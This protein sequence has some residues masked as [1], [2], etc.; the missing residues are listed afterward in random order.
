MTITGRSMVGSSKYHSPG[1]DFFF[2]FPFKIITWSKM[3][4]FPSKF[5]ERSI[6]GFWHHYYSPWS[7]LPEHL[8]ICYNNLSFNTIV[9][10]NIPSS[11]SL[12]TMTKYICQNV[13]GKEMRI[14]SKHHL[15][16]LS[17][18]L[19]YVIIARTSVRTWKDYD[20]D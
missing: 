16:A 14:P 18:L 20:V 2:P 5:L 3:S 10:N 7:Y 19:G 12:H 11:I 17:M 15:Y 8:L 4:K 1:Q 13:A 9:R 6:R